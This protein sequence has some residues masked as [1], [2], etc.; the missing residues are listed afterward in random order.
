MFHNNYVVAC[1]LVK[2]D[3]LFGLHL[4]TIRGVIVDKLYNFYTSYRR[5]TYAVTLANCATKHR[6]MESH[7]VFVS[8]G[9]VV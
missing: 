7:K 6:F 9:F 2:P 8:S 1:S 3:A 5:P 4:M